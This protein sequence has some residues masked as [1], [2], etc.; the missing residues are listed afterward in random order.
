[1]ESEIRLLTD[2][3]MRQFIVQGYL[4]LKADFPRQFREQLSEV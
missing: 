1:M 2:E 3:Q 4:L